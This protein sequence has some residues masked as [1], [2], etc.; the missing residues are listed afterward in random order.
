MAIVSEQWR[1]EGNLQ[2]LELGLD[3]YLAGATDNQMMVVPT[4][5]K[6]A[7]FGAGLHQGTGDLFYTLATFPK[8]G[9][10]VPDG[11]IN[12]KPQSATSDFG[13]IISFVRCWA[14]ICGNTSTYHGYY[15]D[16]TV[17]CFAEPTTAAHT[18]CEMVLCC[19]R[20]GSDMQIKLTPRW[21]EE[22]YQDGILWHW[23][24]SSWLAPIRWW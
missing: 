1:I 9:N 17:S 21:W 24:P 19:L 8:S 12:D 10:V 11:E 4:L 6:P 22:D 23:S 5:F 3:Q 16:W 13:G 14:S 20:T 7:S 18:S 15:K 2:T